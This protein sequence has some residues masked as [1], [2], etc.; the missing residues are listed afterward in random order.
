MYC[1]IF[2]KY[3]YNQN[4][5]YIRMFNEFLIVNHFINIVRGFH[6]RDH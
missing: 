5:M 3:S 6:N 2:L 1:F 4:N